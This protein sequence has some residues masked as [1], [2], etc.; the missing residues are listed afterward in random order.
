MFG[1]IEFMTLSGLNA[2]RSAVPVPIILACRL[3]GLRM[4]YLD[5]LMSPAV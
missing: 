3:M 4:V 2:S 1:N 5:I